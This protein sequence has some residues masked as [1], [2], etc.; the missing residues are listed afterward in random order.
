MSTNLDLNFSNHTRFEHEWSILFL[1]QFIDF[2]GPN[3]EFLQV[4][5]TFDQTHI[6]LLLVKVEKEWPK[7]FWEQFLSGAI[8]S[9]SNF[10]GLRAQGPKGPRANSKKAIFDRAIF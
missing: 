4:D 5:F 1:Q 2:I 7:F 10:F 6:K 3:H 8:F 9:G